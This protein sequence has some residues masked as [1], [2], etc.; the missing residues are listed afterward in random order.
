MKVINLTCPGCGAQMIMKPGGKEAVCEYCGHKM[1]VED[2]QSKEQAAYER[3]M[4]VLRANEEMKERQKRKAIKNKI[5]TFLVIAAVIVISVLV[6]TQSRPKVN[7]FDYIEVTFSGRS[8][9]GQ[10]EI[11]LKDGK[12]EVEMS[13]ITFEFSKKEGLSEGEQIT[14][15]ASS[16]T[17]GLVEKKRKYTVEGLDTYL[18]DLSDLN[19]ASV[20]LI[21]LK[22]ETV[23]R[24]GTEPSTLITNEV[25]SAEP[26]KMFLLTDGKNN[27]LLYDVYEVGYKMRD[28]SIKTVYLVTC[29][30]NIIIRQ[31][32]EPTMDYDGCMYMGNTINLGDYQDSVLIGYFT[33]D[34]VKMDIQSYQESNMKLIER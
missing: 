20:D 1:L 19:D 9:K 28:D 14:V 32:E 25:V 31:G 13:D 10:A 8:G 4:G 3:K 7:P 2:E 15:K 18:S 24:Q 33:L 6:Y 34:E 22:S 16:T 23:N 29:Y 26:V 17:Y 11:Q 12:D 30:K 5:I 21:H 27:N